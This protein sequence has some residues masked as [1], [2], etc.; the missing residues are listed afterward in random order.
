MNANP[1]PDQYRSE[2]LF[3]LVGT[4]PLPNWVAAR[5]LAP[6]KCVL[7]LLVSSETSTIAKRIE[8][9]LI[10]DAKPTELPLIRTIELND[11]S[12]A[13]YITHTLEAYLKQA[14]LESGESIG[15]NYTDGIKAIS[16]YAH[17]VLKTWAQEHRSCYT[18]S[19]LDS[20]HLSFCFAD[21]VEIKIEPSTYRFSLPELIELHGWEIISFED[22]PILTKFCHQLASKLGSNPAELASWRQWCD[23][24][25]RT[26]LG[27][28]GWKKADWPSFQQSR[29]ADALVTWVEAKK[30]HETALLEFMMWAQARSRK[31]K[32]SELEWVKPHS[33]IPIE[34]ETLGDLLG[35]L[36]DST[37]WQ[38][39]NKGFDKLSELLDGTWLEYY[40]LDCIL[41]VAKQSQINPRICD[42]ENPSEENTVQKCFDAMMG[43]T[44]KRRI[45]SHQAHLEFDVA[46]MKGYQLFIF[47]CT[48]STKRHLNKKKLIDIFMRARQIGGD[49]A[50]VALVG[51]YAD[52]EGLLREV[53]EEWLIPQDMIRVFG[54]QDWPDLQDKITAWFNAT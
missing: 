21:G 8:D 3:L 39:T 20:R 43:I 33:A 6:K 22:R 31:Q 28:N 17:E 26:W 12:N 13:Q 1:I 54:P 47:S 30:E 41:K 46:A 52:T 19:Y 18:F 7:H 27:K 4:N 5:L 44:I 42:S 11:P 32:K 25:L 9:K 29:R 49:E 36:K 23:W 45:E 15:F 51:G 40:V 16:V 48:T 10:R 14:G 53:N 34:A 37:G 38:N 35:K 2:H 50:Q 24:N